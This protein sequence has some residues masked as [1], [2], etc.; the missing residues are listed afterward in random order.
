MQG[1]GIYPSVVSNTISVG[2]ATMQAN[3]RTQYFDSYNNVS[4][5]L[6]STGEVVTTFYGSGR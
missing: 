1:R 3:G 2:D 5:I 4:V 6:E